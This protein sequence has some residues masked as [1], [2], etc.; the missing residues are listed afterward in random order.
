MVNPVSDSALRLAPPLLVSD[1]EVD[2]AVAI[3]GRVLGEGAPDS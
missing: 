2:E 3:L 1:R